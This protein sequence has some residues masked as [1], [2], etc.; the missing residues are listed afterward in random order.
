LLRLLYTRLRGIFLDLLLPVVVVVF[1]AFLCI[2][3]LILL[4][5]F[6]DLVTLVNAS[7]LSLTSS[8]AAH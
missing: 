7:P 4:A 1:F 2:L 8:L 3:N 6:L 5:A